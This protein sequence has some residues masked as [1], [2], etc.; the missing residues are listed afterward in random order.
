LN[1]FHYYKIIYWINIWSLSLRIINTPFSLLNFL[2]FLCFICEKLYV[3]LVAIEVFHSLLYILVKNRL[4]RAHFYGIIIRKWQSLLQGIKNLICCCIQFINL[5]YFSGYR[6]GSLI[7][8]EIIIR[9]I[10]WFSPFSFSYSFIAIKIYFMSLSIQYLQTKLETKIISIR[11]RYGFLKITA[12][13]NWD[14]DNDYYHFFCW[15]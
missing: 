2:S 11:I 15:F 12:G 10:P 8:S 5:Y 6:I 1:S 13:D 14:N 3:F 7:K 9:L 4:W